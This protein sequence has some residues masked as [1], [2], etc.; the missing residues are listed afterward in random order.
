[1]SATNVNLSQ[2]ELQLVQNEEVILMKQAIISKVE[3]MFSQR[4]PA[5]DE[6]SRQLP[7][8]LRREFASP[9]ISRGEK[10][11]TLPYVILDHPRFFNACNV[12]AIRTMFWWS[13]FFS[14][15]LHLAGEPLDRFRMKL[16]DSHLQTEDFFV[17]IHED[18]WHHHFDKNN[19]V[20][21]SSVSET[22]WKSIMQESPFVK[23]AIKFKI[24][25]W[26]QMGEML[27]RS[28]LKILSLLISFP[29]GE[30]GL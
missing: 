24:D 5:L 23:L 12:F 7:D 18:Q 14:V 22:Q 27:D 10:Y 19:F 8:E 15:Y 28:Y 11:L 30:T 13:R 6:V 21:A 2:K 25:Q 17:C 9:K 1:M 26:D 4:I 29:A 20:A 3:L 16:Q